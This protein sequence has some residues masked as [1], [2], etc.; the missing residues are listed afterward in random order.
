MWGYRIAGT[1]VGPTRLEPLLGTFPF[2]GVFG[3]PTCTP[4]SF[5]HDA[6][7]A[8]SAASTFSSAATLRAPIS[9]PHNTL[10]PHSSLASIA[11]ARSS[12]SSAPPMRNKSSSVRF[13]R[14]VSVTNVSNERSHGAPL[15]S[16]AR[17][18]TMDGNPDTSSHPRL[19]ASRQHNTAASTFPSVICALALS[20]S[21]SRVVVATATVAVCG[22]RGRRGGARRSL[23]L[24]LLLLL[25]L[26]RFFRLR[27]LRLRLGVAAAAVRGCRVGRLLLG[28]RL[29][30]PRL[31]H[32]L[33]ARRVEPA[34]AQ[35]LAELRDF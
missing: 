2:T 10:F 33:D 23:F 11:C 9:A 30:K 32:A 21:V 31:Q 13:K 28:E 8:S 1:S 19:R 35:L 29:G 22:R 14:I 20:S 17:S 27:L 5:F 6:P 12:A 34:L 3:H 7:T 25:L 4:E 15:A 24:V 18:T 26:L 16:L